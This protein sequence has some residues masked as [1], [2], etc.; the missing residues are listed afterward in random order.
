MRMKQRL[1]AEDISCSIIR[2]LRAASGGWVSGKAIG[3]ALKMSRAAVWKHIQHLRSMGYRIE[4]STRLGY[5]LLGPEPVHLHIPK[6][7][8]S[9]LI[10]LESVGSTNEFAR[11]IASESDSWTVVIAEV[12]TAG[13]GR[14]GR[15]WLSPPGGIWMSIIL[16]PKVPPSEAFR[17]TMAASVAVCRS[18]REL[19]GLN[20]RIKW[21]NDV[22]VNGRKICG[23][24]TEI[25]AELDII[26]HI[27]IGIGIN[28]NMSASSLPE[29]WNATTISAEILR[30]IP[31]GELITRVLEDLRALL[32]S[33]ELYQE[34]VRLSDT[35]NRRVRVQ[36]FDDVTGLV[37]SLEPDGALI[38]RK[39]DGE[40]VRI[41]A[42]DCIHLRSDEGNRRTGSVSLAGKGFTEYA[43]G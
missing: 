39:D 4:A 14:L 12:Q 7:I 23:I 43:E 33:G 27:I 17:Y 21:P 3:D 24:L 6:H 20:A 36:G 13:R 28:A 9:R 42:G 2:M 35:I 29:E 1:R 18:L 22:L 10:L 31:R 32:E 11:E 34:W 15:E 26:N 8:C 25:S 30:E 5:R 40:L 38:V 37:E 41:L 16:K 19:Y